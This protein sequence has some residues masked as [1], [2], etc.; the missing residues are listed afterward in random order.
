MIQRLES[1][2]NLTEFTDESDLLEEYEENQDDSEEQ[3]DLLQQ[4]HQFQKEINELKSFQQ[5]ASNI[6][7]DTKA[8]ALLQALE[9]SF[10]KVK[11]I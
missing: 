11:D 3:D 9:I 7:V 4:L 8:S 1:K 2:K 5:L 10:E 6:K